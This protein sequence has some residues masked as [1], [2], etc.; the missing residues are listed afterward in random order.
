MTAACVA[1]AYKC[2]VDA[3]GTSATYIRQAKLGVQ[4]AQLAPVQGDLPSHNVVEAVSKSL[5][6]HQDSNQRA[7]LQIRELNEL[8]ESEETAC[9]NAESAFDV[10]N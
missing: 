8:E 10:Q 7:K 5:G 2:R 9:S 6:E 3:F 1:T 4:S